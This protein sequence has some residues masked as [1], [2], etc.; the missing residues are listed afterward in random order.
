MAAG[1]K[2]GG[3]KAGT[4]NKATQSIGGKS[5]TQLAKEAAPNALQV[6]ID[7]SK[8]KTAPPAARVSAANSILDRACGRPIQAVEHSGP[9]GGNIP[10]DGW[11]ITRAKPDPA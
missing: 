6:L 8:D 3:R 7:V 5:I 9:E 2:T 11:E 10:F 1:R 4:P